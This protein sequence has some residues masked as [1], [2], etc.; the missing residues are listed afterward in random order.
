VAISTATSSRPTTG[1]GS[2]SVVAP[3]PWRY[4]W[5]WSAVALLVLIAGTMGSVLSANAVAANN[6]SRSR[7]AFRGTSAEIASTLQL[8]IQHEDDLVVNAGSFAT[9]GPTISN[10]AFGHWV[11]SVRA[12]Q[13]YPELLGMG[14]AVIVPASEL[15]AY[16]ARA[17]KDPP[18]S[19]V[20]AG[21][22]HVQP[23]GDRPFY[24]L[25]VAVSARVPTNT[26]PAE[27]DYCVAMGPALIASRDSG[28]GL[29]RPYKV[30]G[31]DILSV[32][33][34]VYR[35]GVVPATVDGR[36]KAFVAWVA[37]GVTPTVVSDRALA[38]HPNIAVTMRYQDGTTNAAF[39][40]G[41]APRGA[42]QVAISL[43]NG[44]TV[45]IHGAV[46]DGGVL[47]NGSAVAL[48]L[49][50]IAMSVLL[51][52][53]VFVLATGRARAWRLVS[54][55]TDELRYQALHD[56]LTGLPNRA[57]ITDRTERLLARNRRNGTEGAALFIDL[58]GFKNVNDTLGHGAGDHLLQEVAARLTTSLREVD[59]IGRLGGDEFVVLIDGSTLQSGPELVANRLLEVMRQP[60]KL[61][62]SQVP[63]T[64]TT[65][66]GIA[67]GARLTPG[68][69]L[70]DAD[71]ALYQAKAAGKNC[72]EIFR[73]EMQTSVSRRN[74]LDFDLRAALEADQFGLVYQPIYN[75]EDLTLVGV[76][77]LIRWQH[78]IRGQIE[79]DEF[80]PLLESS[81]QIVDVGRWVL[82]QACAQMAAWR[83]RGNQLM[84]SV[85][86]S[87]RQ[88][89]R[90]V[91]VD[92]VRDAL[93]T[94]GL[95]P[96]SLTLEVT[97]T[98]IMR[99]IDT[100]SHRLRQLK[101]LGVQVAIDDFGTGYS[102][103]GYLHR[104]PVDCLKIDRTFTDAISGSPEGDA[105]MRTLVQLGRDL[106]LKTLA[107]GVETTG[108]IDYLR[109]EHVNEVQGF[110]LARPLDPATLEGK[111]L[112]PIRPVEPTSLPP[113]PSS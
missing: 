91:I 32:Q 102:S 76:E 49:A 35:G 22:F 81:G 44:W 24:C 82:H 55:K 12:F 5:V 25:T 98:A 70:R 67:V 40:S 80:I 71:V 26:V 78:P 89:D 38:G 14:A 69:L 74:E 6:A 15:P 47:A 79:P 101:E 62:E 3:T 42:Y 29:Y 64:V 103:L 93:Q 53:L 57:L 92:D 85:N 73:P 39:Q 28:Q 83:D 7:Q 30:G 19:L 36:R 50:G 94:S 33:T 106:G 41:K 37:T 68:D 4:G 13:R 108:Q 99:S 90:D 87:G 66:V 46:A 54:D 113:G 88:L 84:V 27:L 100:T 10:A 43:H 59:T 58:D 96:A 77:A 45:E 109:D 105:L 31:V 16:A 9:E 18:G 86:I 97:E 34:P 72:Y 11:T 56:A 23:P 60:F 20:S 63:M 52:A 48:L 112:E 104:L 65:S 61:D 75:L 2:G 95:D 8:A 17:V 21:S 51:A 110:L 107:E 1:P 111:L